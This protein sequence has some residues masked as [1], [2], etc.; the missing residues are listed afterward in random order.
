MPIIRHHEPQPTAEPSGH[1]ELQQTDVV[2]LYEIRQT[3]CTPARTDAVL[4]DVIDSPTLMNCIV[5]IREP[6]KA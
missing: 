2:G 4:M 1:V 3:T 6:H 5:D